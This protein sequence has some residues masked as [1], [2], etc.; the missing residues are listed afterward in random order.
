MRDGYNVRGEH[1][2]AQCHGRKVFDEAVGV[3]VRGNLRHPALPEI[4]ITQCNRYGD[5]LFHAPVR[6]GSHVLGHPV[7]ALSDLGPETDSNPAAFR[8]SILRPLNIQ[9]QIL[10]KLSDRGLEGAA[11]HNRNHFLRDLDAIFLGRALLTNL[12]LPVDRREADRHLAIPPDRLGLPRRKRHNQRCK[13]I[14][15]SFRFGRC[16]DFHALLHRVSEGKLRSE[17]VSLSDQRGEP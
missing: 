4:L 3:H 6:I 8:E 14:G 5:L 17:S 2:T 11:R 1:R 12:H 15:N 9:P 7:Q 13:R 10:F 16:L